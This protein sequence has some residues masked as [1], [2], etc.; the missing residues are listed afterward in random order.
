MAKFEAED[1]FE[2]KG[3]MRKFLGLS[4]GELLAYA[5]VH[6]FSQKGGAGVYIGGVPYLSAFIGCGQDTARK[7]LHSL[8]DRGLI[9]C[10]DATMN[11]IPFRHYKVVAERIPTMYRYTPEK[12]EGTPEKI[13]GTPTPEKFGV[14]NNIDNKVSTPHF[15]PPTLE[16]V[17][18]Y[19]EIRRNEGNPPIDPQAFYNYNVAS[20]WKVGNKSMKD[21]KAAFRTWE[22]KRRQDQ[23]QKPAARQHTS[24]NWNDIKY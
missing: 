2:V 4:G 5:I 10:I 8:A 14:D 17:S 22:D 13:K 18:A 3:W 15:V 21:W 7:Y 20:G 11:G 16:M 9:Q 12:K 1:G 23:Q 6:Q 24:V 19:A